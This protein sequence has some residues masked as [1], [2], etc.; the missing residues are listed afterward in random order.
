MADIPETGIISD[1]LQDGEEVFF[2]ITSINFWLKVNF[3]LY[4]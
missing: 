3:R 1:Y 4:S 2:E